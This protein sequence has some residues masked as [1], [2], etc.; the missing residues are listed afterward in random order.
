MHEKLQPE[1][2]LGRCRPFQRFGVLQEILGTTPLMFD[3]I[4]SKAKDWIPLCLIIH[5]N[6]FFIM[7]IDWD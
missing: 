3:K 5:S 1:I 6:Y 2:S 4:G 7:D